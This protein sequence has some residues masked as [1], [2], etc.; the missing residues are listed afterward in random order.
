MIQPTSSLNPFVIFP[1]DLD[2]VYQIMAG[3]DPQQVAPFL[4]S[5]LKLRSEGFTHGQTFDRIL[6]ELEA[7]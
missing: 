3:A 4:C 7:C 1:A 2:S 6:T 5:Y